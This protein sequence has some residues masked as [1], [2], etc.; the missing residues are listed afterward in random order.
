MAT[1]SKKLG[2]QVIENKSEDSNFN[3]ALEFLEIARLLKKQSRRPGFFTRS[4]NTAW[5]ANTDVQLTK[6]GGQAPHGPDTVELR[7]FL[8]SV[9]LIP[10]KDER[11]VPQQ[12]GVLRLPQVSFNSD[13]A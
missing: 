8:P 2:F 7:M 5:S 1:R 11:L 9:N 3:F 4:T 6:G 10:Q 13:V 12:A